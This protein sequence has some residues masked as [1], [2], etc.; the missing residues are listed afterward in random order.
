MR[1]LATHVD[2]YDWLVFASAHAVAALAA[3]GA[4]PRGRGRPPARPR[5]AAIGHAT[6]AAARR[7][8]WR[9]DLRP[10]MA[11][12]ATLA[13]SL[14]RRRLRGLRV[15]LPASASA[16]PT[17]PQRLRA[18]GA[19][20]EAVTAYRRAEPP[21]PRAALRAALRRGVDV[22]TFTSPSTIEGVESALGPARFRAWLQTVPAIVI[23]AT[24]AG[25]LATRGI[26]PAEIARPST[27]AGLVRGV[28]R[29]SART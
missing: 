21:R 17:L 27:L 24:T 6:E 16:L 2:E 14:T 23:G 13:R 3:A 8:G 1:G 28:E 29:W 20:V 18:A 7:A 15:A 25:A 26:V 19:R 10:R 22:A 9:V 12:A 4:P 5:V 11:D